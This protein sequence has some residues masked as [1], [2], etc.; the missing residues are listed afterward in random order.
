[1][2]GEHGVPSDVDA[3]LADLAHAPHDDVLDVGRVDARAFD[4]RA[5][6]A[7]RQVDGVDGVEGTGRLAAAERGPDGID[8]HGFSHGSS[9]SI[10][11]SAYLLAVVDATLPAPTAPRHDD[12]APG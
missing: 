9:P 7:R 5:E 2:R 6:R 4:E 8:D 12:Y 3:L 1:A 10:M 11:V